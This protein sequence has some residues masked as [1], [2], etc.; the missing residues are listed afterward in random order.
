MGN[1]DYNSFGGDLQDGLTY[2]YAPTSSGVENANAATRILEFSQ[3]KDSELAFKTY[4]VNYDY[5]II[6]SDT[7][8]KRTGPAQE[9]CN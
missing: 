4:L 9:N 8:I 3:K 1:D 7:R 6:P 5:E 2:M